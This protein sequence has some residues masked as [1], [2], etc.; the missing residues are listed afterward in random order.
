VRQPLT[1]GCTV[2]L[3]GYV[4]PG[5]RMAVVPVELGWDGAIYPRA[6]LPVHAGTS[7]GADHD[8]MQWLSQR[9]T[10]TPCSDGSPQL[11]R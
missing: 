11:P 2:A 6:A 9:Q 8:T 5:G 1:A 10:T 7:T 4:D 3:V